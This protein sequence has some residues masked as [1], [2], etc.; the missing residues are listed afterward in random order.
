MFST[1]LAELRKNKG[2]TQAEFAKD[3]F[4]ATGTIGMWESGKREPNHL[5]MRRIADYFSVS[6]D[7]LMGRDYVDSSAPPATKG[8]WVPVLGYVVAGM[9]LEAVEEILDYEEITLEMAAQGEHFGL[10]IKGDSMAP[11]ILQ[12]DIVIVR[13]QSA[14]ESGDVC[15]VLVNGEEATVKRVKRTP[16]GIMLIPNNTNYEPM[17]YTNADIEKLPIV[18]L[19][20]VVELRRKFL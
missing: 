5:T 14:A 16:D 8:V 12:D 10:V 1:R 18:I 20:V 6:V 13:K 3:F 15:V 2:L 7:Y 4:I 9:P 17:L 11:N 19:G